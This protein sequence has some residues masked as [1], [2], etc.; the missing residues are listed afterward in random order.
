MPKGRFWVFR[1]GG[2]GL[3][4]SSSCRARFEALRTAPRKHTFVFVAFTEEETGLNGSSRYVKEL[5][6]EER[7]RVRAFVN[8]E[9]LGVGKTNVWASRATP[10]LLSKLNVVANS[11]HKGIRANYFFLNRWTVR[12]ATD[13]AEPSECPMK[14]H[15]R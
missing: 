11:I 14:R 5:S 13:F 2:G 12:M 7:G 8:L 3:G 10:A 6:A 4:S 9:C 15:T 1:G